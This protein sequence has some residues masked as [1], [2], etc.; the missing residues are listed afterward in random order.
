[1]LTVVWNITELFWNL[2]EVK[3]LQ[4]VT[5]NEKREGLGELI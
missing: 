4:E 2:N 5:G 1:M 3:V